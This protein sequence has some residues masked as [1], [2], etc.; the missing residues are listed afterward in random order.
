LTTV[1]MSQMELA[2]TAFHALLSEVQRES[3]SS[4]RSEYDLNTSLVLRRSTALAPAGNQ[5]AKSRKAM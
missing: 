2:R 1:Q 4:E 5:A 3:P